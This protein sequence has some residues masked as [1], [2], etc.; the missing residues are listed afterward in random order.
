MGNDSLL[1]RWHLLYF[2][3]PSLLSLLQI[4]QGISSARL[5]DTKSM[6]GAVLDWIVPCHVPLNPP[7]AHNVKTNCG[8]Q[9]FVTGGLLCPAGLNW[10][11][12]EYEDSVNIC[13][14]KGLTHKSEQEWGTGLDWN[15]C[16]AL[17]RIVWNGTFAKNVQSTGPC[18][19][20]AW[21]WHN[22]P[23]H[24]P[25]QQG[26]LPQLNDPVGRCC[27]GLTQW[28]AYTGCLYHVEQAQ[29]S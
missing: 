29:L 1:C 18:H 27:R 6:K 15:C 26:L 23:C 9:H 12:P 22:M 8:Y 5:D 17:L 24:G 13:Y 14:T 7:I 10:H 19:P 21:L 11:D 3:G 4:Q 16:W 20:Q 2:T 25:L 28:V